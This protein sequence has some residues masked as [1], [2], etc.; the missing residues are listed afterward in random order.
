MIQDI[1]MGNK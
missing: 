1:W